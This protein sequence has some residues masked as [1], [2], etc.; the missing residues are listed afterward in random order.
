ME[1]GMG[2]EQTRDRHIDGPRVAVDPI[3]HAE[4]QAAD[5][6]TLHD[7]GETRL[8]IQSGDEG[9][10]TER[11]GSRAGRGADRAVG[12]IDDAKRDH[13][14][15]DEPERDCQPAPNHGC[16]RVVLVKS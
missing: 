16:P 5:A 13:H 10:R 1:D 9:F 7:L 6:G 14:G 2:R 4:A 8:R 11:I 3:V 12:P 15:G